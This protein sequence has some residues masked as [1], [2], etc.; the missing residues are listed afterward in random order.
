LEAELK[1]IRT[2]ESEKIRRIVLETEKAKL[3]AEKQMAEDKLKAETERLEREK[4]ELA[5]LW[6]RKRQT[7]RRRQKFWQRIVH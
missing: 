5:A 2:E 3:A 6:Q 1:K 4:S 7:P